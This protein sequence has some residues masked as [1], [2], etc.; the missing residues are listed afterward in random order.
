MYVDKK[1][2]A[3]TGCLIGLPPDQK[4]ITQIQELAQSD[5]N[6]GNFKITKGYVYS[7]KESVKILGYSFE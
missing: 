1:Q 5:T 3:I 4:K 2:G 7:N 6:T